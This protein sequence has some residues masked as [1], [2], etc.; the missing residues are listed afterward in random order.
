MVEVLTRLWVYPGVPY[1]F[2]TIVGL[3]NKQKGEKD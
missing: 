2:T 1:G 3:Q